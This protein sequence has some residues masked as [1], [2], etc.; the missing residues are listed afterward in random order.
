MQ[1]I[2]L[3]A[4]LLGVVGL[5]GY[6]FLTQKTASKKPVTETSTIKPTSSPTSVNISA[7][8]AIFTSGTPRT[9]TASRYHNLSPDV[10]I[11]PSY[12]NTVRVKKA[13]ITW[14]DFFQT[15]PMKLSKECLVT[16]TNQTFCAGS[17]G[18]L[19]FYLDDI[20]D[21]NALDKPIE[22]GSKLTVRFE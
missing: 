20:E 13:G 6:L 15:L 9:F 5:G 4:V 1:K 12:S 8:F 3:L 14:N 19:K 16:G 21:P 10:F 7:S 22:N 11:E 17:G 2:I 18:T